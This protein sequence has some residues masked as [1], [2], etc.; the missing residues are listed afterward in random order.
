MYFILK[1]ATRIAIKYSLENRGRFLRN[2]VDDNSLTDADITGPLTE[3]LKTT[4]FNFN[5]TD[6]SYEKLTQ[7]DDLH[8]D[9]NGRSLKWDD[10]GDNEK[11]KQQVEIEGIAHKTLRERMQHFLIWT[12]PGFGMFCGSFFASFFLRS[13]GGRRFFAFMMMLSAIATALL[14]VVFHA[15]YGRYLT[16][17]MRFIQ[18][19]AFAS[20][21]PMIGL[22][23]A[24]WGTL[25]QQFLFLVCCIC[26]IQLAP[27][28]SWPISAPIFSHDYRIPFLAHASLTCLLA[29]VWLAA[30]REKPQY[31][32]SVNGLE[33][34]KIVAGKIKAEHNRILAENPCRPLITSFSVWAIWIS[35]CGYFLVVSLVVQFLPLYCSLIIHETPADSALLA[36][37]PFLFM[38]VMTQF[39]GLWCRLA[40]L[41]SERMSVIVFNTTSFVT[42]SLIFIFLA[43]FPPGGTFHRSA[44]MAFTMILCSLT[45]SLYGFYRSAVLVGRFFG[46]FIVSYI[47]F[48]TGFAF[49]FTAAIVVFF[50]EENSADEWRVIFL[51]LAALL[52]ISAAVFGIF[53][54]ASPEEWSKDSWDPSA[55]R[56]MITYDQIDY[57]ADECGKMGYIWWLVLA[58]TLSADTG[59]VHS[60]A[61]FHVNFTT[62]LIETV[63]NFQL[64]GKKKEEE[65]AKTMELVPH[66]IFEVHY[67]DT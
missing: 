12:A 59:L 25:K 9:K 2:A 4:N 64:R 22:V 26:F 27:I 33:L 5:E 38:L 63:R 43:I 16:T 34:N 15:K 7:E 66:D 47:Q 30:F 49:F 21:F 6:E 1:C 45:F 50:V 54:S 41:F 61:Q 32:F 56:P 29:L 37:V 39:H 20:V 14:A 60:K 40:K 17:F 53:G 28:L 24:N 58:V 65:D 19:L 23:T 11:V 57:H 52:L 44:V 48:F 31:H 67:P 51:L 35:A 10:R 13:F 55:A 62:V 3:R 46:Q 18:G 42:C 36:A 8:S